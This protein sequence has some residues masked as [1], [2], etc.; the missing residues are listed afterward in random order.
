MFLPLCNFYKHQ[1]PEGFLVSKVIAHIH[2]KK[3]KMTALAVLVL[4]HRN[5]VKSNFEHKFIAYS[6]SNLE[7]TSPS[8]SL[9]R[10][11][12]GSNSRSL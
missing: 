3:V 9:S 10:N 2:F 6:L 4:R 12:A 8:D 5:N 11:I 7:L 1:V